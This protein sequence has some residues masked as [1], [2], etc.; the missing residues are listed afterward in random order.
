MSIY[1]GVFP[2]NPDPN[3][4]QLEALFNRA[5]DDKLITEAVQEQFGL[6]RENDEWRVTA[7]LDKV[8]RLLPQFYESLPASNKAYFQ[9]LYFNGGISYLRDILDNLQAATGVSLDGERQALSALLP[10]LIKKLGNLIID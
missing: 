9:L 10:E 8:R 4:Y 2:A 6:K 7:S 1:C 5:V 3:K